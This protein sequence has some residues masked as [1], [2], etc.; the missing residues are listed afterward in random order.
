MHG[1]IAFAGSVTKTLPHDSPT[2]N[3]QATI[4][5]FS[6]KRSAFV[7]NVTGMDAEL[8][9]PYFSKDVGTLSLAKPAFLA[10]V[11]LIILFA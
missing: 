2:P 4:V 11:S 9:F 10:M 6:K 8:V 3:P 7:L 5:R 1:I